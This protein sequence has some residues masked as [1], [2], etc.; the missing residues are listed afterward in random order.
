MRQQTRVTYDGIAW[1]FVWAGFPLAGAGV[2]WLLRAVAG[3]VAGLAWAPLQGP[4]RLVASIREPYGTLAAVGVGALLGLGVALLAT[5]E[6]LVLVID[7]DA[8][9][10][11]RGGVERARF[12]RPAVR[13][14][15]IDLKHLVLLGADGAELDRQECDLDVERVRAAFERHGYRWLPGDPHAAHYR[16]W[17]DGD[18]DLTG[19]AGALLRAR[20]RAVDR[21]EDRDRD[22]FRAELA[23]LGVVVRDEGKRQY[24]RSQGQ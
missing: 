17:V 21:G 1:A 6:V 15:F 12:G 9:A 8:V 23:R 7:D 22:E 5:L 10:L 14:V 19:P 20:Q 2:G 13:G 11:R 18:P 4:F 3:W 16:R 24:W